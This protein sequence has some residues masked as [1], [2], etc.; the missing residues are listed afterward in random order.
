MP[1]IK[2]FLLPIIVLFGLGTPSADVPEKS[3]TKSPSV[4]QQE[5]FKFLRCHCQGKN[6]VVNWGVSSI[7]GVTKFV[8]YHSDD[9]G[10]FYNPL[11]DD[12]SPDGS[13]KYSYK[14]EAVFAGYHYYYVS[15][16]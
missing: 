14:Q 9:N 5:F 2:L 6:I 10:E 1:F 8:V 4:S 3:V 12:V 16:I 15:A 13:T 7:A 11:P